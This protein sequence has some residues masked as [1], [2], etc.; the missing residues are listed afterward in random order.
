M[1]KY[2][3][4]ISILFL[5]LFI[6]PFFLN[7]QKKYSNLNGQIIMVNRMSET[8]TKT[9]RLDKSLTIRTI[10]GQKIEG[11]CYVEDNNTIICGSERIALDS[12]YLINGF[13]ARNSK[14]KAYG[15]GLAFLSAG[16]AIYPLYLVVGGIG[17]GDGNALFV[18]LTLLTF[19][20]FIVYAAASLMGIYP[21]R[22]NIMNWAIR[23]EPPG[24]ELLMIPDEVRVYK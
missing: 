15:V 24:Q 3:Y 6:H 20:L 5:I 11:I 7:A 18:G 23:M 2:F 1:L 21:R 4:N 19:D 14:E 17:L 8:R 22:F 12:I 16:A 10:N 9:L 13:V